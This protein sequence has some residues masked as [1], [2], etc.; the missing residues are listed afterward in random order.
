M[1][2]FNLYVPQWVKDWHQKAVCTVEDE[3]GIRVYNPATKKS[4]VRFPLTD[5]GIHALSQARYIYK[6]QSE[7]AG[8]FSDLS[9]RYYVLRDSVG[10]QVHL[11]RVSDWKA[12]RASYE[13]VRD[14]M[15][16]IGDQTR[17]L[18]HYF[19]GR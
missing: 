8:I 19:I 1:S 9:G 6:R 18:E 14:H 17:Q 10:N 15:Q 4:P 5:F 16:Q 11:R 13:K 12:A 2:H 3:H 7:Q